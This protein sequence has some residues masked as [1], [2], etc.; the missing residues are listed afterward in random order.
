LPNAQKANRNDLSKQLFGLLE[1]QQTRTWHDIITVNESW[2][3]FS[4]CHEMIWLAPEENNI[5]REQH[6]IQS[7]NR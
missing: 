6:L 1:K 4:T 5:K 3:Y 2:F 7:P